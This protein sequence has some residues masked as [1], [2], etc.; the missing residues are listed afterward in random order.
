M[1]DDVLFYG[2]PHG[3]FAPLLRACH[4][5]PP[6]GVIILGDLDLR[7]PLRKQLASIFDAG[8]RVRWIFGNH[9]VDCEEWH[10]RLFSD[11][12]EGCLHA[13]FAE[14]GGITVAGLG[15]LFR[16]GVWTPGSAARAAY[17][18]RSACLRAL[19]PRDRW[20]G[21]LPLNLRAAIFPEDV[22]AL[23]EGGADVL[24]SHEAPGSHPLGSAGIGQAAAAC[25]ARAIIHG[26][27]HQSYRGLLPGGVAVTGLGRAEVLRLRRIDLPGLVPD[28]ARQSDGRRRSQDGADRP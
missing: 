7:M 17:D 23:A 1:S 11:Y 12:P 13:R 18:T 9:D 26:H 3:D 10:D 5:D 21:G 4:D 14:V 16:D 19:S 22:A 20:R 28:A 8:I 24:V 15:G 27:H 6:A 25:G 2:D